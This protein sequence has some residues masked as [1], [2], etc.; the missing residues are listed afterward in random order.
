MSKQEN[1]KSGKKSLT[2][3]TPA[4]STGEDSP[5][6]ESSAPANGP[7]PSSGRSKPSDRANGR[8][9]GANKNTKPP[10]STSGPRPQTQREEES[11]SSST[12]TFLDALNIRIQT[13][14]RTVLMKPR[15]DRIFQLTSLWYQQVV[16]ACPR[17]AEYLS[18]AEFQHCMRIMYARR[19][20][21]VSFEYFGIKPQADRRATLPRTVRVPQPFWVV[22]KCLG[23]YTHAATKTT[24]VPVHSLPSSEKT[25]L[26]SNEY[27]I[28]VNY[29]TAQ[30][31]EE[32]WTQSVAARERRKD[33]PHEH[34]VPEETDED[35]T[36]LRHDK[37]SAKSRKPLWER[38]HLTP[39]EAGVLLDLVKQQDKRKSEA[40]RKTLP[41]KK[42]HIVADDYPIDMLDKG[43]IFA[44][45]SKPE[46]VY[47]MTVEGAEHYRTDEEEEEEP[48]IPLTLEQAVERLVD[49]KTQ[50]Q[51]W[52][53]EPLDDIEPIVM[54]SDPTM[55]QGAYGKNLHWDVKLWRDYKMFISSIEPITLLSLSLPRE[56]E[57][58]IPWILDSQDCDAE[59][60][61]VYAPTTGIS[62]ADFALALVIQTSSWHVYPQHEY[63]ANW[64]V[65]SDT[66]G[67]L[68]S[69]TARWLRESI[70]TTVPQPPS[71]Y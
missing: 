71:Y 49:A 65:E 18:Q 47:V 25:A 24:Y 69:V 38:K 4:A 68:R 58:S 64:A 17:S 21:D 19:L 30:D 9:G 8:G 59:R 22:L 70:N 53:F 34:T 20:E 66:L 36:I 52:Q 14:D 3:K 5:R 43:L 26:C 37:L 29:C 57:G 11:I 41:K 7:G 23:S 32:S 15:T 33:Y 1:A 51:T 50:K 60:S 56:T 35:C 28:D 13:T 10:T 46:H 39:H 63:I 27:I 54:D 6:D 31:W 48:D 40:K 55:A 44:K 16:L 2:S 61:F 12:L 67:D 62:P 45:K 42:V